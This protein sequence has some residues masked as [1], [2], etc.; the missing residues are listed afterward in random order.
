MVTLNLAYTAPINPAN[1]SPVL[2]I[3]QV[4][5]GLQRKIRNAPEFVGAIKSCDVLEDKDTVV[6]REVVFKD[7]PE[8][9]VKEVCKS[10]EPLKVSFG[11]YDLPYPAFSCDH[12]LGK[13]EWLIV[14][15]NGLIMSFF[16]RLT[17]TKR[18][19]R[20]SVISSLLATRRMLRIS[21]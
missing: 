6:T 13:E 15:E 2:S 1:A 21:T 4:W 3:E 5:A 9:R 17:F 10:Y 12:M 8:I 19:A 20:S 16:L 18:M 14:W 11:S 7:R